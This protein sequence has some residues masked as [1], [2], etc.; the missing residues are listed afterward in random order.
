[1]LHAA[2]PNADTASSE[3][4]ALSAGIIVEINYIDLIV[5]QIHLIIDTFNYEYT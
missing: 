4:L 2:Y 3:W 1:V 5:N